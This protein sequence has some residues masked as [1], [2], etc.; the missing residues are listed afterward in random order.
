MKIV[1]RVALP[2][3]LLGTIA[4]AGSATGMSR[5]LAKSADA[6][7]GS[8]YLA[9]PN[10]QR[11]HTTDYFIDQNVVQPGA[12]IP[13]HLAA[14]ALSGGAPP[15]IVGSKVLN[16][17]YVAVDPRASG[18]WHV[19]PSCNANAPIKGGA[20]DQYD[21]EGTW[22]APNVPGSYELAVSFRFQDRTTALSI[23][24]DYLVN[25]QVVQPAQTPLPLP[26]HIHDQIGLTD[27][28]WTTFAQNTVNN[29]YD[30]R[31]LPNRVHLSTEYD[32]V[33]EPA[34][35]DRRVSDG[36]LSTIGDTPP[37]FA[38]VDPAPG[39][40]G[41]G[42][43]GGGGAPS[44]GAIPLPSADFPYDQQSTD[45]GGG[46]THL[47]QHGWA[48]V[49]ANNR[50]IGAQT[51]NWRALIDAPLTVRDST[52][53][54]TAG[55]YVMDNGFFG[56]LADRSEFANFGDGQGIA[57]YADPVGPY[58]DPTG[59]HCDRDPRRACIWWKPVPAG[60]VGPYTTATYHLTLVDAA[61]Q[62][63]GDQTVIE[64][65][66]TKG[67]ADVDAPG[68]TTYR[69][70]LQVVYSFAEGGASLGDPLFGTPLNATLPIIAAGPSGPGPT[71]TPMIVSPPP[72]DTPMP[73]PPT[74]TP[75]A[76]AVP[77][78]D[79]PTPAPTATTGP[80][81]GMLSSVAT[82]YAW[83]AGRLDPAA[84]AEAVLPTTR[85]GSSPD[86]DT[87]HFAW[88]AGVELRVLP[89]LSEHPDEAR[90]YVR[91]PNGAVALAYPDTVDS[92][93]YTVTG[94]PCGTGTLAGSGGGT[95]AHDG[96]TYPGE[97]APASGAT[98][99]PGASRIAWVVDPAQV[100]RASDGVMVCSVDD[101]LRH[102][103][104]RA[105][106]PRFSLDYTVTQRLH[107][108]LVFRDDAQGT[109]ADAVCALTPVTPQ[110]AATLGPAF[111][112]GAPVP[113]DGAALKAC[114]AGAVRLLAVQK[115]L[116]AGG[117][118]H[119]GSLGSMVVY[120]TPVVRPNG[121]GTTTLEV[122]F[123]VTRSLALGY[124]LI[125]LHEVAPAP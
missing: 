29:A 21:Y 77:P 37:I 61:R 83:I 92:I 104:G 119:D 28:S 49:D 40:G 95:Y 22:V 8:P 38:N 27:G 103:P 68:P 109:G 96:D 1:R 80:A 125:M 46:I 47:P 63:G 94:G 101:Y 23:I 70:G 81:A 18:D 39:S 74:D 15:D 24:V 6:S 2:L 75:T 4:G 35:G 14:Y 114:D 111:A 58:Y 69:A 90:L 12:M 82:P 20:S 9:S 112:G 123:Q 87:A 117:I 106:P 84:T 66:T 67:W 59:A 55:R 100:G 57:V 3:L 32:W 89:A 60:V 72:T 11:P 108:T 93:T 105:L 41:G 118:V 51:Y 102:T 73:P 79:T 33:S 85:R 99:L 98:T 52:Y 7:C 113:M 115:A 36:L 97:V 34:P 5:F 76:T 17:R 30:L 120:G 31:A 54:L 56:T 48:R 62:P 64:A 78:T 65:T 50:T 107:F 44:G 110:A 26:S 45:A 121:D 16:A 53:R 10:D 122:A 42:G 91:D 86:R 88:P 25:M 13:V 71:P 116:A 124:H 43:R 19:N